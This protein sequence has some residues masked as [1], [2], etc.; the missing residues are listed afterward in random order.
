MTIDQQAVAATDVERR[1]CMQWV[2]GLSALWAAG[3]LQASTSGDAH[4]AW[5]VAASNF[6]GIYDDEALKRGFADFLRHVYSIYPSE[7]FHALIAD[8]CRKQSA[9]KDIYLACQARLDEVTPWGNQVRNALPALLAQTEEVGKQLQRMLGGR[10]RID[11]YM[12]IGSKGGYIGYARPELD[13]HGDLVMLSDQP[14]TYALGD[15]IE[16]RLISRLGRFVNLNAYAPI[17]G[18]SVA[19][20]SLDVVCNPIG[21]HHAPAERRDD[22]IRSVRQCLRKGGLLLVRDHDV[23]SPA[24]NLMVSLAHDVFNMGLQHPWA[25]NQQEVRHFQSLKALAQD[26]ARFG[27]TPTGQALYQSGDPTLNAL[28]GFAAV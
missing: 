13:L 17:A 5:S 9:D 18:N 1:R 2:L 12:E 6:H 14:A 27:F 22:F 21:F 11:G 25:Q 16:R 3:P 23:T 26:L 4:N 8:V 10:G 24:M 20:G 28:V 19:P 7:R 15:V